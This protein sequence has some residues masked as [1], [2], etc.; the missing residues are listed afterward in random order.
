VHSHIA[1]SSHTSAAV[2]INKDA[3][4]VI[5]RFDSIINARSVLN[6]LFHFVPSLLPKMTFVYETRFDVKYTL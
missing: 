6:G 4:S 3:N 5:M 2:T 1:R